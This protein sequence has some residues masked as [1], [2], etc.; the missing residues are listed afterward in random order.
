MR[1]LRA[2]SVSLDVIVISLFFIAG[3]SQAAEPLAGDC[4]IGIF[5]G[6]VTSDGRPILWK[7]RD[8]ANSNQRFIYVES[9]QRD[10]I[11]TI[12]YIGNVYSS[13]SSR[14]YMGANSEGFAVINSNSHNLNDSLD[15]GIDDGTLMRIALETCESIADFEALL[16]ST[17][18]I[19]RENC[20][21][22]G[23]MDEAGECA[24]YECGNHSYI[25]LV[26][27]INESSGCGYLIRAN[28]SVSGGS[29]QT[30]FDRYKRAIE[31]TE[32]RLIN[33]S[34][35]EQY[36]LSHMM[37]DLA[38]P[39][40]NPYPWPYFRS[41]AGGPEGYIFNYLCTI[42]NNRTSSAVAIKGIGPGEDPLLTTIYAVVG[43]PDLSM[44]Y[45]LWVGA[46]TVPIFLSRPDSTPMYS[47]CRARKERL[48]DN[49]DAFFYINTKALCDEYGDG[50]YSYTIPLENWGIETASSLLGDWRAATPP[51][52]E[53]AMEQFS[54][55]SALFAG[56]QQE[57]AAIITG[58]YDISSA[59]PDDFQ[60]SNY[61]NPFNGSTRISCMLPRNRSPILIRIYDSLG[62]FVKSFT[63][64]EFA[65]NGV[66]W[67]GDDLRGN[68]VKSGVYFYSLE[69]GSIRM[70]N[71]MMLIK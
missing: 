65:E 3:G 7:N 52:Y 17:D 21:N 9:Y 62:R 43:S 60:L 59:V 20:W 34:I 64:T 53:I 31:L 38:N 5:G 51:Y 23:T 18:I 61:P 2:F 46:R 8:V 13:D 35:D 70:K 32:D 39:Y 63:G 24:L 26:P 27:D 22:F 56:F 55:A 11:W 54:I 50:F 28:F 19:G 30:G 6:G 48:Y 40:D 14:V 68:Y 15:E 16:D 12:P 37:R 10:G 4:T 66:I 1:H 41:Q 58:I 36:I 44:A 29:Q 67:N 42:S 45:P 57:N 69:A 25:K 71:K 33:G 47:Y 49:P